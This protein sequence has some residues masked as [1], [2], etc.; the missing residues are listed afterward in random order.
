LLDVRD[1]MREREIDTASGAHELPEADLLR[2][3]TV[4]A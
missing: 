2:A 4:R 1:Q 3:G